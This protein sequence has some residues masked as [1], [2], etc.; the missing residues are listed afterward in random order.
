MFVY[1]FLV[2][3]TLLILKPVRNSLF[4]T[5]F[6][7]EQLPYAFIAMAVFSAIITIVYSK[8]TEG[9]R[10]NQIIG[11]SIVFFIAIFLITWIVFFLNFDA[12]WFIYFFYLIASIFGI[13]S[14]SQFWL[15]ANHIFNAR[16]A[17]RLFG[18]FGSGAIIGGIFGGYLTNYIAPVIGSKNMLLICV[19]FISTCYVIL[20]TVWR[21]NTRKPSS[22]ESVPSRIRHASSQKPLNLIFGSKHL[23]YIAGIIIVA[24]IISNLVDYQFN[25]VASEVISDPDKLTAFFGFWFSN[26]SIFSLIIQLF[27]TGIILK[28]LGVNST[29]YF[30]PAIITIGALA[31]LISPVL[32][33]AVLVK[34]G[35][36]S[37]K[38]SIN[39]SGMELLVLPIPAAIKDKTKTFIDV[40]VD[41]LATGIAGLSLILLTVILKFEVQYISMIVIILCVLQFLQIKAVKK[42]Y[43]ESFRLAIEKRSIDLSDLKINIKDS[44]LAPIFHRVF[45]EGNNKQILYLLKLMEGRI[46]GEF[47]QYL[48]PLLIESSSDIKAQIFRMSSNESEQDFTSQAQGM[49]FH[50]DPNVRFEAMDYLVRC[51]TDPAPVLDS[52][53]KENKPEVISTAIKCAAIEYRRNESKI[54]IKEY[55][56]RTFDN[57][58][59]EDLDIETRVALDKCKAEVIGIAKEPGLY[60]YLFDLFDHESL[61]VTVSAIENAGETQDPD[62]IPLLLKYLSRRQTKN[63]ARNALASYGDIVV[64]KL[65]SF[66]E[67]ENQSDDLR[68]NMAKILGKINTPKSLDYL[69][70]NLSVSNIIIRYQVIKALNKHRNRNRSLRLNNNALETAL[71]R[72][73]DYYD[74]LS[75]ILRE[76]IGFHDIAQRK[77]PESVESHEV[78]Y[79][80]FKLLKK[81]L[82]ERIAY[83]LERIFRLLALKYPSN[84]IYNAYMAVV[85]N[86]PENQANA[87]E[88]IDN[89]LDKKLKLRLIP[90]IELEFSNSNSDHPIDSRQAPSFLSTDYLNEIMETDDTFLKT[91]ALFYIARLKETKLLTTAKNYLDSSDRLLKETAEYT[92]RELNF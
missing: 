88:F 14:A 19:F 39:K 24:G 49:V 3:A 47:S 67:D 27:L 60:S 69:Q 65:G 81:A 53:L 57:I 15:L 84:D 86:K 23:L 29:L 8:F 74:H 2:I 1:I 75:S 68:I 72:E 82:D 44:S 11:A 32:W 21:I 50:S 17:K 76:H 46:D 22:Y 31:I 16:E 5:A 28:K 12:G 77:S 85:G 87:L 41:N 42:E 30:L 59:P 66:L 56:D 62:F 70:S 20:I 7:P 90:I 4:L 92:V 89:I 48:K 71:I 79:N 45:K 13:F 36:G 55:F 80:A 83:N 51:A 61:S 58:K 54:D 10:L 52:F 38:Q 35:E 78:K 43:I 33:A 18:F 6:G 73:F 63:S 91:F 9:F 26:I 25:A 34:V 40:F 37:F 64:N